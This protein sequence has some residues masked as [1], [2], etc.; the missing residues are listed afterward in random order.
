VSGQSFDDCDLAEIPVDRN[1]GSC[2]ANRRSGCPLVLHACL[3]WLASGL[4]VACAAAVGARESRE[5][6]TPLLDA[7]F[8]FDGPHYTHLVERGY[9][10]SPDKASEVAFFPGYPLAARAVRALTGLTSR[11]ALL[12]VANALLIVASTLFA[13]YLRS[14]G[15]GTGA[16]GQPQ[17]HYA[18]W[19]FALLPTTFFFRMP[20]SESMFLAVTF[21]A[22]L[23]M[24]R[25]WPMILVATIVGLAT[26]V[27]PVGVGLLMPLAWYAWRETL[28]QT[29]SVD[30]P[31]TLTLSRRERE[32]S[33]SPLTPRPS[34]LLRLAW[35]LPLGCW[36]LLA[37][38]A[39]QQ[40]EFGDALAFAKTQTYWRLRP[41][42]GIADK[43]LSLASWEPIWAVYVP[44]SIGYFG[45]FA[46]GHWHQR[47]GFFNP[48]FFCGTGV[49]IAVGAWKRWLTAYE[50]L[51]SIPLLAIPYVTRSY[52]MCM[53]S[54]GRFAAVVIPAYIVMGQLL[55]RLPWWL[56][57]SL[58]AVS[59]VGLGFFT[60]RYA[61]GFM[62]F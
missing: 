1:P 37:Y 59:A 34:P 2:L 44:G 48:I 20:Y 49:L 23:G 15:P 36:G 6:G 27:R 53:E 28:R 4:L 24:E 17:T 29:A 26:A 7:V 61:A 41:D 3:A 5:G 56:A 60:A 22:L 57:S 51:L 50:A 10:Y 35:V 19:A 43:A 55:A 62:F 14:R 18:I 42:G 47:M 33:P 39:F 52:E 16:T 31:L 13:I 11:M 45:G 32:L 25:R 58:L 46:G 30:D 54:H 21:L 38:M 8:R 9:L 12:V 40:I